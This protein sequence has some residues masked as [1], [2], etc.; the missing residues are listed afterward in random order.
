M[1][2]NRRTAALGAVAG[3]ALLA[4]ACGKDKTT[5]TT[6]T[7]TPVAPTT[8]EHYRSTIGIGGS[9]FY[10]FSV[11]QYGTVNVTLNTVSGVDDP[12]VPIGLSVGG[13]LGFG[14][15]AATA[16]TTSAGSDPQLTTVFV[17]GVYCV[18]VY[19]VGNLTGP[20]TFDVTIAYP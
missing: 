4:I 14:C 1:K 7:Q 18:R 12:A 9:G 3:L 11:S 5:P 20:A 19:D 10:S 15:N 2:S 17:V 13:P 8:S 16:V 6:P